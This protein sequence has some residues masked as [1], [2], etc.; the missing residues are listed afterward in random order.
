MLDPSLLLTETTV[1]DEVAGA[2]LGDARRTS[3]LVEVVRRLSQQPR[4][5]VPEAMG[6]QAEQEAYYRLMRNPAVDHHNLLAGHLDRTRQRAEAMGEVLV[7]HDT[8]E[9]AFA[10]RDE[11]AREHLAR[12]S[13]NRQ[14][15]LWHASAVFAADGTRAPLGLIASRP[16]VHESEL[17]DEESRQ[18]WS[19]QNG[20]FDNEMWRWLEAV[21]AAEAQLED[22]AHPIHVLDREGDDYG[23]LFRMLASDYN[24]VIRMSHDRN[25]CDG[26]R[27]SDFQKLSQAIEASEF[28]TPVRTVELSPRPKRKAS[29]GHPVRRARTAQMRARAASLELRRPN[30]V[31]AAHAPAR[32]AVH[33]VEVAE[34]EAPE[35]T[36]PVRWMLV[37][38]EPI[39]TIEDVWRVVDIYRA[40]WTI[41]E[42]FKAIKT[43]TG[44]TDLQHRSATTLL[45]A[46]STKAIIAWDLLRLRHIGRHVPDAD[47]RQVVNP[48]QLAILR[49]LRPK[50]FRA[51]SKAPTAAEAMFAVAGLGGHIRS[52]GQPGWQVLGRGWR[53]LLEL[54][55]GV[56]LAQT[57]EEEM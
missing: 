2:R 28:E 56:R 39:E 35:G 24:F 46:L 31:R 27:H 34:V 11:P 53:H 26:P 18:F 1:T 44:Y 14:S 55:E 33:V 5:S 41:E 17:E 43:G 3:R 23:L 20:L 12:P 47:A 42:F 4:A 45:N 36:E 13:S 6:T 16:F 54:E 51:G 10:I 52:N 7:V 37:T 38:T 32:I 25:V 40:R 50:R 57:L 29:K 21:E 19:E 8:T 9:F 48:I 22:V 15:F 30:A 49:K